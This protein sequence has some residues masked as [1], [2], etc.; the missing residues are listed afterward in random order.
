VTKIRAERQRT[1]G[2]VV[3]EEVSVFS[4]PSRDSTV[5][6]KVHEGTTVAVR[7]ASGDWIRVDLPGELSG[8]VD[9]GSLERI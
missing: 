9:A 1:Q 7:D 8:W 3:T 4:G 6:F 5:Q 2:V